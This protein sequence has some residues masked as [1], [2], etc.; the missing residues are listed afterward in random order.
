MKNDKATQKRIKANNKRY[1]DKNKN[2]I[3]VKRNSVE[4]KDKWDKWYQENREE[5]NRKRRERY[6]DN[7]DKI[8]ESQRVSP[9]KAVIGEPMICTGCNEAKPR[10]AIRSRKCRECTKTYMREKYQGRKN[11]SITKLTDEEFQL[12]VD[13]LENPPQP[14]RELVEAMQIHDARVV[15]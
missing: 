3:H 4:G 13:T 15:V 2:K 8:L 5:L 14:A 12:V 7:R 9:R 10:Y 6:K 1:Y 11:K